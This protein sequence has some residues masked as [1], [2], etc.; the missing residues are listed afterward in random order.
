MLK[1]NVFDWSN[2]TSLNFNISIRVGA[3]C[4]PL[5]FNKDGDWK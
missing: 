4:Q 5:L 3:L 1:F 2:G